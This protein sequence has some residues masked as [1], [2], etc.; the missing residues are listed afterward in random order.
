[1]LEIMTA[2]FISFEYLSHEWRVVF[3]LVNTVTAL[4]AFIGN[5]VSF[6]V[7]SKTSYYRNLS[8]CF[9]GSLIISD[10]LVGI[11]VAPMH[12]ALLVSESLRKNCAVTDARGYLLTLLVGV[13]VSSIVL[14]SYD[15][16]LHMTKLQ[17]YHQF[18]RKSKA[19][20]LITVA[21]AIPAT[22]VTLSILGK[23]NRRY[24][25]AK[26]V[27]FV[28]GCLYLV[29]IVACYTSVMKIVKKKE[30]EM[31]DSQTQDQIQQRRI[32]NDIRVAKVIAAIIIC[33]II[34]IIPMVTYLCVFAINAFLKD[35]IPGF[36]KTSA[37]VYYYTA[38]VTLS[39]ANSGINPLI[40]YFR[41]PKFKESLLNI[42]SVN[43]SRRRN[44]LDIES[45]RGDRVFCSVPAIVT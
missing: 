38:A 39:M 23:N 18:M 10:L 44:R 34:T 26:M 4:V 2:C 3:G 37:E 11:L 24:G 17:N 19:V 33:F 31:A 40:Y 12:V 29:G 21:W 35:G 42:Y 15:R 7:I 8:T 16:Y 32:C 13:S 45:K 1:M 5:L 14:I 6:V 30:K 41:N 22:V 25:Y 43:L 36:N 28:F 20:A 27:A 9:L